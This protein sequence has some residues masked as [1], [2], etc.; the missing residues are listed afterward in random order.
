[1]DG[2]DLIT[3]SPGDGILRC[4]DPQS[5]QPIDRQEEIYLNIICCCFSPDGNLV[6]SGDREGLFRLWD[7]STGAFVRVFQSMIG[8]TL[9]IQWKQDSEGRHYL[10]TIDLGS[11][12]VWK[13]IEKEKGG[14]SLLLLWSSGRKELS[15]EDANVCGESEGDGAV[16]LSPIDLELMK[17]RGAITELKVRSESNDNPAHEE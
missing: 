11:V 7:R 15:L 4:W 14:Y 12:R 16:G 13:L 2:Q 9:A 6:A 1:M 8:L 5:G 10:A 3:I 17:Q